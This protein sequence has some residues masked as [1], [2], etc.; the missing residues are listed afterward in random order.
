MDLAAVFLVVGDRVGAGTDDGHGALED[1][2]ELG[3][4]VQGG[5]A[6]ER[7][8]RSDAGVALLRL[9]H[10]GSVVLRGHGTELPHLDGLAV[11]AVALLLEDRWAGRGEPHGGGDRE[12]GNSR[13]GE[14]TEGED[15]VE[16]ALEVPVGLVVGELEHGDRGEASQAQHAAVQEVEGEEVR[17]DVDGNRRVGQPLDE[18]L[19][20]FRRRQGEREV[21]P[22]EPSFLRLGD[23]LL[24]I[25]EDHVGSDVGGAQPVRVA[26][27]EPSHDPH[28]R[29]RHVE[30]RA[31]HFGTQGARGGDGHA[32]AVH[33]GFAEDAEEV[34]ESR[35]P[36][37]EGEH[38]DAPPQP[39][40]PLGEPECFRVE[41][42]HQERRGKEHDRPD[43]ER[44][45]QFLSQRGAAPGREESIGFADQD[46]A[47][48]GEQAD[49]G[50]QG[51]DGQ[52]QEE[53]GEKQGRDDDRAFDHPEGRR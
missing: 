44:P 38:H 17:D 6:E 37:G 10:L 25:A 48:G 2:D 31:P 43:E 34:A 13:D 1:V 41:G 32:A 24:E 8:Q 15:E 23:E 45:E 51:V 21:H 9:L 16:R 3:K 35:A 18:H 33:S 12:H 49:R 46:V 7:A 52:A 27:V 4:L 19:D 11:D 5:L 14:E 28:P 47:Q 40:L 42:L 36:A 50:V 39:H 30:D 20:T 53:L 29:L 26:V 22:V